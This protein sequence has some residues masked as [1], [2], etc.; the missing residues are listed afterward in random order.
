MMCYNFETIHILGDVSQTSFYVI[1]YTCIRGLITA[2][3][4]AGVGHVFATFSYRLSGLLTQPLALATR[5]FV[6]VG[7][8]C[9]LVDFCRAVD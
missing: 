2:I 4:S 7:D 9:W 3:G 6:G 5:Q 8:G 1:I